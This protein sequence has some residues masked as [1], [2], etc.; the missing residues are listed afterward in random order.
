MT[1]NPK[2]ALALVNGATKLLGLPADIGPLV[3]ATAGYEERV[4]EMVNSDDDIM[5]YV[6]LLE[7]RMDEDPD[8]PDPIDPTQLPS[9]DALAAEFERFLREREPGE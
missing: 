6:H 3:A 4:D 8:E 1:P 2:A 7:S 5:E 9:G